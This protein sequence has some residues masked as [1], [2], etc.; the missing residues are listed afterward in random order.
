[1]IGLLIDFCGVD[2]FFAERGGGLFEIP[3]DSAPSSS[4]RVVLPQEQ[5]ALWASYTLLSG[6]LELANLDREVP[7]RSPHRMDGCLPVNCLS[8]HY[9]FIIRVRNRSFWNRKPIIWD[10]RTF[11]FIN[12]LDIFVHS[13]FRGPPSNV[14]GLPAMANP[15]SSSSS[16]SP[17]SSVTQKPNQHSKPP[18]LPM[19]KAPQPVQHFH[20]PS[21]FL[22]HSPPPSPVTHGVGLVSPPRS[23]RIL[24]PPSRPSPTP[25]PSPIGPQE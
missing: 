14:P 20:F 19:T 21:K 9:I 2:F 4:T 22:A 18:C 16:P 10:A 12:Y 3:T 7:H 23:C 1:M 24:P 6:Q 25:P 11:F 17:S 15:P 8:V 13:F 5:G